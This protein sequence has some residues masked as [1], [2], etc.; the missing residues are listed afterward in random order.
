MNWRAFCWTHLDPKCAWLDRQTQRSV[1]L[2]GLSRTF[3]YD[4]VQHAVIEGRIESM[5]AFRYFISEYIPA[6]RGPTAPEITSVFALASVAKRGNSGLPG[7][8][9]SLACK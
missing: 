1:V 5:H 6:N 3:Q 8:T 4:I 7:S 2:I 9:M